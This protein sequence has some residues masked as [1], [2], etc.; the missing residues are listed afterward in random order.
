MLKPWASAANG[1]P[2]WQK[3]KIKKNVTPTLPP[4]KYFVLFQ[5]EIP[6][7][8]FKSRTI[9][10]ISIKIRPTSC[11]PHIP[12]VMAHKWEILKD[13]VVLQTCSSLLIHPV[14]LNKAGSFN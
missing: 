8:D 2:M 3:I 5:V 12:A 10:L 11:F 1:K 14:L 4:L 6:Q 9:L 7:F 13:Q